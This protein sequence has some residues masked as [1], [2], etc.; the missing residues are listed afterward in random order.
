MPSAMRSIVASAVV[1]SGTSITALISP[2]SMA[3]AVSPEMA[4]MSGRLAAITEPNV[5]SRIS[6]EL[7][8]R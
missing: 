3:L 7:T 8:N 2:V 4:T 1:Q 5:T 6:P